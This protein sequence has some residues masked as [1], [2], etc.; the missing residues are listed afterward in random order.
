M[1]NFDLSS[2]E[3]N[4]LYQFTMKKLELYYSNPEHIPVSLELDISKIINE[5]RKVGFLE[6]MKSEEAIG[7]LIN[8]MNRFSVRTS[9]PKYFGL[10]NPK[11]NFPSILGDL[12]I[13]VFN[14]QLAAWSH[15]PFANEIE[16]YLISEFGKCF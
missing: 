7:H 9:L 5:V 15:Y 3:R 4:R 2:T 8:G 1:Q 12:I 10:F 14:P 11:S 13:A 6:P 16:N